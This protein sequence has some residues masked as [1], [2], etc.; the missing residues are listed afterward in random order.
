MIL[1]MAEDNVLNQ[2]SLSGFSSGWVT[3]SRSRVMGAKSWS[4]WKR[5]PSI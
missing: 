2:R 4:G 3:R 5:R 1:T